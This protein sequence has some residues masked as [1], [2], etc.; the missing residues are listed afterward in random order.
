MI[1]HVRIWGA[2]EINKLQNAINVSR[3]SYESHAGEVLETHKGLTGIWIPGSVKEKKTLKF[4]EE[5]PVSGFEY[6]GTALFEGQI[7]GTEALWGGLAYHVDREVV[8]SLYD[9]LSELGE[10]EFRRT[11]DEIEK[12]TMNLQES[13]DPESNPGTQVV[14]L[15]SESQ[16]DLEEFEIALA[17]AY[18]RPHGVIVERSELD[19][20]RIRHIKAVF[21]VPH[22]I[23]WDGKAHEVHLEFDVKEPEEGKRNF[24]TWLPWILNLF[25]GRPAQHYQQEGAVVISI[26]ETIF[27]K[28]SSVQLLVDGEKVKVDKFIGKKL[29]LLL[30]QTAGGIFEK[31]FYQDLTSE[32][33]QLYQSKGEAL[34]QPRF[35]VDQQGDI[36]IS[37]IGYNQSLSTT[38]YVEEK[39]LLDNG[40]EVHELT[41]VLMGTDGNELLKLSFNMGEGRGIRDLGINSQ[42]EQTGRFKMSIE[43][44]EGFAYGDVLVGKTETLSA[45]EKTYY[46]KIV[47]TP[48]H[49]KDMAHKNIILHVVHTA[50]GVYTE[51]QVVPVTEVIPP[52]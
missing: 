49:S 6:T 46:T 9:H 21:K 32:T 36:R 35:D 47:L 23:S 41:E 39:R 20:K 12:V 43:G 44:Q 2:P 29:A 30:T 34:I 38:K 18:T 28:P 17:K 19:E 25:N 31:T 50:E 8:L 3:D 5:T 16:L 15:N 24:D 14:V 42:Q 22:H 1:S 51:T 7:N 10:Q 13:H 33:A 45:D 4:Y 11:D 40:L 48:H 27:S 37:T 26:Q 52:Q